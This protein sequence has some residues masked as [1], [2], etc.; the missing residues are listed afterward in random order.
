MIGRIKS[1]IHRGGLT[2]FDDG[3]QPAAQASAP[4]I[5]QQCKVLS[6]DK[7]SDCTDERGRQ[8]ALHIQFG[9]SV[10]DWQTA[11]IGFPKCSATDDKA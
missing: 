9:T 2:H 1:C 7:C 10:A 5:E 6:G 4:A 11:V 3:C 8:D